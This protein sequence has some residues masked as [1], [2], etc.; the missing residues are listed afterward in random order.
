ME[1]AAIG[2]SAGIQSDS[3]ADLAQSY[4]RRLAAEAARFASVHLT[5]KD[6]GDIHIDA[7]LD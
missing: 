3:S 4:Q 1:W 7:R 6:H 5:E 2:P